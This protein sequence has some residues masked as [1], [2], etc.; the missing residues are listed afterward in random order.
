MALLGELV[1]IYSWVPGQRYFVGD[2][3]SLIMY[4]S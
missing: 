2:R 4:I 1:G 3:F